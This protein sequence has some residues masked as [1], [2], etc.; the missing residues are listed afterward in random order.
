MNVLKQSVA[1]VLSTLG[2]YTKFA[3]QL[4]CHAQQINQRTMNGVWNIKQQHYV[5]IT[6]NITGQLVTG[7]QICGCLLQRLK[8]W[9]LANRYFVWCYRKHSIQFVFLENIATSLNGNIECSICFQAHLFC[10]HQIMWPP[11]K[12][13]ISLR[14]ASWHTK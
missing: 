8:W 14:F 2:I 6:E 3:A 13:T 4:S 10:L 12:F 7:C 9:L 5:C 11:F 1:Q